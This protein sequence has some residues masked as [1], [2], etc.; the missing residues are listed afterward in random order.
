MESF[1]VIQPSAVLLPYV[2][3]YWIL[4][5]DNTTQSGQRI[6]PNGCMELMFN[7]G[8]DIRFRSANSFQPPSYIK[9]QNSNYY[10]LFPS[11]KV[12]LISVSFTP[13]G[14][15]AFFEMPLYTFNNE[16]IDIRDIGDLLLKDLAE[17]ISDNVEDEC[18][19]IKRIENFLLSR[20]TP[21]KNYNQQRLSAVIETINKSKTVDI[22]LLAE[23][24]CLSYRQFI[25]VFTDHVGI[26]PKEY[27][28]IVR[29]QK[30]L[31]TLQCHPDISSI[32]LA[33]RCGFYD[34]SHL[35]NEFKNLSGY[36]PLEYPTLCEPRSDYFS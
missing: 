14:G 12:H 35:I 13:F 9:G 34:Q 20:F 3:R 18:T 11:G 16:C 30:A 4:R 5:T 36:T 10:D 29:F 27:L 31:Y 15:K 33:F 6:I 17:S 7:I 23:I 25:R 26:N 32:D 1:K 24:S 22:K 21:L 8:D 28:R 2:Q 19:C